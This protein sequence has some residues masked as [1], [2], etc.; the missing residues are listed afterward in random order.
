M[1]FMIILVFHVSLILLIVQYQVRRTGSTPLLRQRF[2][3]HYTDIR[4][5]LQDIAHDLIIYVLVLSQAYTT[6]IS[7][8]VL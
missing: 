2:Y 6:S 5:I 1:Q 4:P 3:K 7:L 8:K